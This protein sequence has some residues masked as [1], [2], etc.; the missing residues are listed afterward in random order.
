M[1]GGFVSADDADAECNRPR[2]PKPG[3]IGAA[4]NLE[5]HVELPLVHDMHVLGGLD[6]SDRRLD[7]DARQMVDVR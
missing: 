5:H 6:H 2:S 4:E 1:P 3:V 7:A